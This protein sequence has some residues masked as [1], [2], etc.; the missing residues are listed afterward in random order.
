[1]SRIQTYVY[2][3]NKC[4][5]GIF[6]LICGINEKIFRRRRSPDWANYDI[7]ILLLLGGVTNYK[8]LRRGWITGRQQRNMTMTTTNALFN[9]QSLSMCRLAA[10][11]ATIP[12]E[13]LDASV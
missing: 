5:L 11:A 7:N 13:S 3:I 4:V 12:S 1:M 10:L 9:L 8:K 2:V 6:K